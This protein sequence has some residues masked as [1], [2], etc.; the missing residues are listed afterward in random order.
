MNKEYRSRTYYPSSP[1]EPIG[2]PVTLRISG[3][4]IKALGNDE[5]VQYGKSDFPFVL[6]AFKPPEELQRFYSFPA[7]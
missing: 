7:N 6:P 5:T 2:D 4:P 1:K 3:F